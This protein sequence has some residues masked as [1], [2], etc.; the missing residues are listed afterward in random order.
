MQDK[1]K[2]TRSKIILKC[3]TCLI[4]LD[5]MES[6]SEAKKLEFVPIIHYKILLL[7]KI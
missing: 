2:T 6:L 1:L 3:Q 5:W 7:P 4:S